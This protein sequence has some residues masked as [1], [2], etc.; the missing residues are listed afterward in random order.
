MAPKPKNAAKT[1]QR[2]AVQN[3]CRRTTTK[4]GVRQVCKA[5]SGHKGAHKWIPGDWFE[6]LYAT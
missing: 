3:L 6:Q 2:A 4:D 1:T 5:R